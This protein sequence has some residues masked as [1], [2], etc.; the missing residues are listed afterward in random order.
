[1]P[2]HLAFLRAINVAGHGTLKMSALREVFTSAGCLNVRTYIQSGNII[3]DAPSAEVRP[4]LRRIRVA[5]AK[6]LG[7]K[8]TIILRTQ[9]EF[10]RMVRGAPFAGHRVSPTTKLYVTFLSQRPR[11]QP[12]L[13]LKSRKEAL[14]II[15]L[16]DREVFIV[17]RRKANG[18][19]GF[20]NEVVERE[21][22]V[23][24]TSRNWSTVQKLLE[25][26]KQASM[27]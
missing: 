14:D 26:A 23:V 15:A 18:F 11:S 10:E 3:F 17:S 21:L 8:P 2:Q 20:P 5:L 22:G 27:G 25:A 16:R 4:A 12:A 24:A 1:M 7:E 19:Y 6:H 13:P 9:R